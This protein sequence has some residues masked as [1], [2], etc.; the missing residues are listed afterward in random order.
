M[1][2][3][4]DSGAALILVLIVVTVLGLVL[5]TL[6]SITDTSLR[7]TLALRDQATA[8]YEAD[9][10]VQAAIN[11]LRNGSYNAAAGQ[12]CFGATDTLALNNFSGADSAAVTC[13]ADPAKVL[14]QCPS[15]SSCNRP[16]TAILTLGRV[17]GEDGVNITQPT[18][19][20]FN[21]H[22]VVFSNSNIN[23]VKGSLVTN[24]AAYARGVCSGTVTST[25][26]AQCN[27]G[28]TA[29]PLG[30]DP[31][32]AATVST[33]PAH[34]NLP[35]CTTA[36]SV[37]KF[38]PGYYDDAVG[39]SAMMAGNSSCKHST[40]WFTPGTYYF[41]FHNS[42]N[43]LLGS[44][45][46]L[47]TVNDG[48]LVAGTPVNSAGGIIAQPPVP[49][50]IPGACD[51]PINDAHAVGVQFVFGGDSQLA[52][53]AGQAE[54]CGT[55]SANKP[56][57]AVYGLTAGTETNSTN[58]LKATT[59][60]SPGNFTNATPAS[61][62]NVDANL[63]TWVNTSNS[64][65][66]TTVTLDGYGPPAAIPAGSV[67]R[68]AQ[69]R[70]VHGNTAGSTMDN[71]S[72]K[73]TPT[74][75][76]AYTATVPSYGDNVLHTDLIDVLQGGTGTLAQQVYNG[77]FTGAQLAYTAAVK[78]K[79]TEQLDAVQLDLTY[80]PPAL[81]AQNGCV[82]TTPYGSGGSCAVV[83]TVNNAGGLFYVQ[84]TT[85]TPAAVLDITLNNATEQV[86][87]FG[88]IARSLWVKE[89]G[90]FGYTGPVIE[91]PDDAPGF[92][93]SVFLS[94]YLCPN[95]ATC[96]PGSAPA[97]TARVAIVDADPTT[98]APGRRQIS[99]L[100]WSS[101]R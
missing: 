52:V 77:T 9:G 25:P 92:V 80:T 4:D 6:L 59:V 101:T 7:T 33:V 39:L 41:D 100:S 60:V 45:S 32:Y 23:M 72:V 96:T 84:G 17:A 87:R 56:P 75:G 3:G 21:V 58:T 42:T 47:W 63:A 64:N 93:L 90:S 68:S 85:Y 48:Y 31:G 27:Y 61:L 1:K 24:A 66:S 69:L 57:I 19:S 54:V 76:T 51:N 2:R 98:P 14:I 89:T 53:K 94:A 28:N 55:Y 36:N 78:H 95:S 71:L 49:A 18:G 5:G 26:A 34:Q 50:A 88:V 40:W 79:G 13:T 11:N 73:I 65:Q 97:L 82:T 62:S 91:V 81:R 15:L 83:T 30:D 99:V 20:A 12:H 10:A 37:V 29:N 67:L 22:G 35:A 86:F 43:P 44:G 8:A 38:L 16:G 46:D 74:G 70:V